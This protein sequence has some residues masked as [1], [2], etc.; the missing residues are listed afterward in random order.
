MS[1]TEAMKWWR[2]AAEQGS[3]DAQTNLGLVYLKGEDV[4]QNFLEAAKWWRL[5]A[6]QGD[7]EARKSLGVMYA[8][9]QGLTQDFVLAHMWLNLSASQGNAE[10]AKFLDEIS[11]H[12]TAQQITEAESIARNCK[13]SNYSHCDVGDRTF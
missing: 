12:M 8:Q 13:V 7:A 2:L 6:A 5:A 10:A 4:A 9:G 1:V 3:V 11:K